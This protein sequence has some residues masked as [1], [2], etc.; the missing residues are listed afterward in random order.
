MY[1]ILLKLGQSLLFLILLALLTPILLSFALVS[2]WV[3]RSKTNNSQDKTKNLNDKQITP[4][5]NKI[6]EGVRSD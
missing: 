3:E 1:Y 6:E 4:S 2:Y 5:K